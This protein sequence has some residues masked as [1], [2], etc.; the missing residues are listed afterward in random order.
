VLR[1]EKGFDE[2]VYVSD[3]ENL[4]GY[5]NHHRVVMP[6]LA[7]YDM[8]PVSTSEIAVGIKIDQVI[9]GHMRSATLAFETDNVRSAA[10]NLGWIATKRHLEISDDVDTPW[11]LIRRVD[12]H[13]K[14]G[15]FAIWSAT[16]N[17]LKTPEDATDE[18]S[19]RVRERYTFAANEELTDNDIESV[20]IHNQIP[21]G[22]MLATA[23]VY[24]I[25]KSVPKPA[26]PR[27]ETDYSRYPAI[28]AA[29]ASAS[30]RSVN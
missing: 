18:L 5:A 29:M 16:R 27:H 4:R 19:T 28:H 17:L 25:N 10:E 12:P 8:H 24:A 30:S 14:F 21:E 11:R 2:S 6:A 23:T 13:A 9:E 26:L 15:G 7:T 1:L 22:L 20:L 3:D